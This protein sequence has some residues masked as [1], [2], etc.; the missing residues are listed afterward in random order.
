MRARPGDGSRMTL[1]AFRAAVM[2]DPAIQQ[3]LA[4]LIV[5]EEFVRIARDYAA[6][7]GIALTAAELEFLLRPDPLGIAA[8]AAPP[9]RGAAWPPLPWL[10]LA[11]MLA[12]EPGVDWGHFGGLALDHAFYEDSLRRVIHRPFNR[13]FRHRT[14]LADFAASPREGATKPSGLIFHMSRCGSTLVS[15]MLA[16]APGHIMLSEPAPLDVIIQLPFYFPQIDPGW[17]LELFR[18]MAGALGRDR[19]GD[20]RHMFIKTDSWH[21]LSLPLFRAAFPDVPWVFL[22]RDP[23]EVMVSHARMP[24]VQAVE[25]GL[26]PHIFGL[27]S[28]EPTDYTARVL[29]RTC[30]AA[31]AQ[32]DQGGLLVNYNELPDAVF[33]RILPHFGITPD[34]AMRAAMTTAAGRDAK[35]G[36]AFKGDGKA[37]QA[38]ASEQ[39]RAAADRHLSA[40]YAE[41]ESLNASSRR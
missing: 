17:H 13:A 5:P 30:A 8:L 18:A 3:T 24:G 34:D 41:M 6:G 29:E 40:I 28:S 32:R 25:G 23:V 11:T 33:T 12:G 10:P 39:I 9:L 21:M 37:K 14:S 1:D 16:A 2:A 26:P 15:Q 22:Y 7:K 19:S 4:E 27:D 36:D 31:V 20:A 35:S 38:E